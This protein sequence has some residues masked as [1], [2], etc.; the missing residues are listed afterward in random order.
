VKGWR[1]VRDNLQEQRVSHP[2]VVLLLKGPGLG[3]QGFGG[4]LLG[5]VEELK[6][7]KTHVG[8]YKMIVG[9]SF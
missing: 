2:E 4:T 6:D 1:Q 5:I 8:I 3:R 9:I 7:T